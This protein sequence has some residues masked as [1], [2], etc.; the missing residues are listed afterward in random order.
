M[1]S[2]TIFSGYLL[3]LGG[4]GISKWQRRFFALQADRLD[5][6]HEEH[7]FVYRKKVTGSIQLQGYSLETL[8]GDLEKPLCFQLVHE[9]KKR[10]VL[11][12]P[13]DNAYKDWI[14]YLQKLLQQVTFLPL[15]QEH[16]MMS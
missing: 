10:Y 11:E 1:E 8:D 13:N 2:T 3:K 7:E 4:F 16:I 14:L 15:D 12:A 5:Y 9:N 6:W